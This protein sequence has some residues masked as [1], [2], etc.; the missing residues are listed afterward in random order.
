MKNLFK[1]FCFVLY[2]ICLFFIPVGFILTCNLSLFLRL[3]SQSVDIEYTRENLY[4]AALFTFWNAVFLAIIY[5]LIDH[6]RRK[7]TVKRP[8]K[9]ILEGTQ[10][11]TEGDLSVRI[12]PTKVPTSM[13]DF[14]PIINNLNKM[15]EEL[16]GIE[17]LRTDFIAN[18]SHELKTPLA[19]LQNYGTLLETPDLTEEKRTEYAKAI[20]S[21]TARLSELITNILKLNKLENQN[22]YPNIENCCLSEQICECLLNFENEWEKKNIEIETD[23][24]SDIFFKTDAELLSIVWNNLFSNAIKFTN[25]GGKV[26][27]TLKEKNGFIC[28]E[29]ADNGCGMTPET[30]KHIFEKFYQGDTSHATHGNGLGLALVKR[31]VDILDGEIKVESVLNEGT[32][33]TVRFKNR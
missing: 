19:A 5:A 15:V 29:V 12:K 21:T 27:I 10:K 8:V 11:I 13:N 31:V 18:V 33:F 16:S 24:D 3:L 28:A 6:I 30:G 26:T 23:I 9:R 4:I 7:I 14:N 20:V 22:I 17:T 25:N 1:K 2:R 32:K